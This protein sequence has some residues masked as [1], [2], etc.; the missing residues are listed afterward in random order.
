MANI[1]LRKQM[2]SRIVKGHP[3][4]FAN[5]IGD[6]EGSYTTGDIVALYSYSGSFIGK[7]FINP[8]SQIRVRLITRDKNEE[9]NDEFFIKKVNDAW[10]Y[11]KRI[12]FTENCRVFFTESDGLSGLIIDKFGDYFVIQTLSYGIDKYKDT[13]IRAIQSV[14]NPK[15]IYERN[16]VPV[17]TLE[18]LPLTKG[19][20]SEEFDTNITINQYDLTLQIDIANGPGTGHNLDRRT[21]RLAIQKIAKGSTVL[22]VFCG[23]GTYGLLAAKCDATSVTGIDLSEASIKSAE[24]NAFNNKMAA[25]CQYHTANAFDYL[26][27]I[28]QSDKQYDLIILDPPAFTRG[29]ESVSKALN[30]YKEINLRAILALAPNGFLVTSSSSALITNEQFINTVMEASTDAKKQL[31]LVNS[32]IQSADHPIL[33]QVPTTGYYKS[34]VFQVQ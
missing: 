15:G 6:E 20:I 23:D 31:R 28:A 21:S 10:I 19:F 7:G 14:F 8:N 32:S 29:R 16:D 2:G 1:Y 13:I 27:K 12:G 30:A 17:R 34:L 22:D 3:W 25:V 33:P 4:V 9:I 11:R 5:E 24:Q 26:K 18:R